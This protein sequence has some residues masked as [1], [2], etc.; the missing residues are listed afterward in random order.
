MGAPARV[1][2]VARFGRSA[3]LEPGES[4]LAPVPVT[5]LIDVKGRY[6][7]HAAIET[8]DEETPLADLSVEVITDPLLYLPIIPW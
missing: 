8:D 5:C 7:I 4:W 3:E 6:D 2:V 1:H